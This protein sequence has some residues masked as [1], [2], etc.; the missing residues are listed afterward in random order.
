M[1]RTTSS[2]R[3]QQ[4]RT[5]GVYMDVRMSRSC[6]LMARRSV[7]YHV[8]SCTCGTHSVTRAQTNPL[9][10]ESTI[11]EDPYV[12]SSV[13]FGRGRFQN[14]ILIEPAEEFQVDAEN[15]KEVE[16]FRNKIWYASMTTIGVEHA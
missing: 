2:S 4:S 10:I 11:N 16:A 6:C 12:K 15:V 13:M 3:T 7:C 9:P 1:R 8:L 14:G 5:C